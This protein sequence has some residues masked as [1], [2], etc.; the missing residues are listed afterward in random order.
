MTMMF[1][2]KW[3]GKVHGKP[4]LLHVLKEELESVFGRA[5]AGKRLKFAFWVK[6]Y[7][8]L[9]VTKDALQH[10]ERQITTNEKKWSTYKQL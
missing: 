6:H 1:P 9:A 5:K 3:E 7:S 10:Y 4:S 2:E 8:Q